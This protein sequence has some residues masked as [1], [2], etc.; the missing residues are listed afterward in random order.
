MNYVI[1]TPRLFLREVSMADL[2]FLA[3]MMAD[4]E[5]MR[6]YPRC[7]SREV[8]KAWIRGQE[9][10][11]AKYGH[12]N[13]LVLDKVTS[14]PVGRVGLTMEMVDGVEMPEVG[15]MIHRPYWRRGFATEAANAV[16]DYA[17][18][19][20]SKPQVISLVRPENLP[21]QGVARK[22]GMHPGD[23]LVDHGGFPHLVFSIGRE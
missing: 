3:T 23:R 5:V 2:E 16:R 19:K 9:D 13:W 11:Y 22:L 7:Y 17:F 21:S 14:E 6:F 8:V 20:L 12:G 18:G 1:E 10:S 15:Y 4:P